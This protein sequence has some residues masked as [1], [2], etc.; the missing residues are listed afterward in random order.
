M[1]GVGRGRALENVQN[2]RLRSGNFLFGPTGPT[3]DAALHAWLK[4]QADADSC[5][6]SCKGRGTGNWWLLL[7]HSLCSPAGSCCCAHPPH[8]AQAAADGSGEEFAL[9]PN[10]LLWNFRTCVLCLL[11]YRGEVVDVDTS[12]DPP[13]VKVAFRGSCAVLLAP[14][15]SCSMLYTG[16]GRTQGI[17]PSWV[18]PGRQAA[19][20]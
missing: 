10:G 11:Q 5:A 13:R 15:A 16:S 6:V 20:W 2:G 18:L 14:L 8:K 3:C 9:V 17:N 19:S 1:W 4:T 12:V 7:L